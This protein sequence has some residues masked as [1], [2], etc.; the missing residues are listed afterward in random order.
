LKGLDDEESNQVRSD[1]NLGNGLGRRAAGN[2][3]AGREG[4]GKK[5]GA[6]EPEAARTA[7]RTGTGG[8]NRRI[9]NALMGPKGD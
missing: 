9:N 3:R 5:R 6:H 7:K 2:A 4:K 8:A 1:Q